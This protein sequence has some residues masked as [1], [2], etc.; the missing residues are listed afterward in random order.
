MS[1]TPA[2]GT[3]WRQ[4]WSAPEL[5]LASFLL[6]F[7]LLSLGNPGGSH[8][9]VTPEPRS[10]T[11]SWPSSYTALLTGGWPGAAKA[12][13][14][15]PLPATGISCRQWQFCS[16]FQKQR[17]KAPVVTPDLPG[18]HSPRCG[19]ARKRVSPPPGPALCRVLTVRTRLLPN[20]LLSPTFLSFSQFCSV[21]RRKAP[22]MTLQLWWH[23]KDD[24]GI[25]FNH[26]GA[27]QRGRGPYKAIEK[28]K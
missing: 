16:W 6:R 18:F 1:H 13:C 9:A 11:R 22:L 14:P 4:T 23:P 21:P 17:V 15:R 24:Y 2:P 19:W 10:V 3:A 28:K 12:A 20:S 7:T 5:S 27:T 25:A 26:F 8:L